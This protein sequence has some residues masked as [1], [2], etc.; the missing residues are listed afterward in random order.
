MENINTLENSEYNIFKFIKEET[1]NKIKGH[2]KAYY[3]LEITN[4]LLGDI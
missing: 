2:Y 1:T 3:T 4:N